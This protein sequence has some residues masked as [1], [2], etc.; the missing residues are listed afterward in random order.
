VSKAGCRIYNEKTRGSRASPLAGE[1]RY[2]EQSKLMGAK[3]R[4][5]AS[6]SLPALFK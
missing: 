4:V 2:R 3:Y 1:A 6:R 5:L